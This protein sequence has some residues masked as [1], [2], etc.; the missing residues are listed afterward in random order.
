[1]NY[2]TIVQLGGP[3]FAFVEVPDRRPTGMHTPLAPATAAPPPVVPFC[4]PARPFPGSRGPLKMFTGRTIPSA[5]NLNPETKAA[6]AKAPKVA[7][8]RELTAVE[9]REISAALHADPGNL[10][11]LNYWT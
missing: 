3:I 9:A 6:L 8:C 7:K 2:K 4:Y 10:H 1:M 11:P 5:H